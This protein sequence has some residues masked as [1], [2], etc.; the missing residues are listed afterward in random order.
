[1]QMSNRNLGVGELSVFPPPGPRPGPE[2]E[3]GLQLSLAGRAQG[4]GGGAAHV[5]APAPRGEDTLNTKAQGRLVRRIHVPA[6][7]VRFLPGLS[8]VKCLALAVSVLATPWGRRPA[9]TPTVRSPCPARRPPCSAPFPRA[10]AAAAAAAATRRQEERRR[11]RTESLL[12]H[13]H[14]SRLLWDSP[15]DA[16]HSRDQQSCPPSPH[17][18]GC[19]SLDSKSQEHPATGLPNSTCPSGSPGPPPPPLAAL[20]RPPPCFRRGQPAGPACAGSSVPAPGSVSL[21]FGGNV[22]VWL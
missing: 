16:C 8:S 20:R 6:Y 12:S 14:V 3:S 15:G 4:P 2:P 17:T 21:L 9:P 18:Q 13:H 10:S 19:P 5:R 11:W 22:P 1:M 7:N